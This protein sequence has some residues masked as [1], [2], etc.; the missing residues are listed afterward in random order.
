M[1]NVARSSATTM[2]Q[3]RAISKP[4]PKARPF[5]APIIGL[6]MSFRSA[7]RAHPVAGMGWSKPWPMVSRT[8]TPVPGTGYDAVQTPG[9]LKIVQYCGDSWQAGA[10]SAF[11]TVRR[12]MVM[13]S[14]RPTSR[15]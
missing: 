13:V 5:T 2:S 3:Q 15:S 14:T 7:I 10:C 6:V 11:I 4:P 12:S 9:P 1:L 8:K